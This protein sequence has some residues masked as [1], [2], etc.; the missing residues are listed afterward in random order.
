MHLTTKQAAFIITITS[1]LHGMKIDGKRAEAPNIHLTFVVAAMSQYFF[2][3]HRSI[4]MKIH[5]EKYVQKSILRLIKKKARK[6]SSGGSATAAHV[7][8]RAALT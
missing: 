4:Q 7:K 8:N 5:L 2:Q 6:I 3:V 1:I